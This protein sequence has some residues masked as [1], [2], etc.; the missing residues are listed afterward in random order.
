MKT[1]ISKIPGIK[2]IYSL[3]R[4]CNKESM[5]KLYFY[6]QYGR[7]FKCKFYN[8]SLIHEFNGK[9][10]R[11]DISDHLGTIFFFATSAN[12]KLMVELG[13]RGG[14][15]TRALLAA[16]S[17][18]DSIVLS[19][20]IDDCEDINISSKERWNFV[21]ADDIEFCKKE[22][23]NWCLNRSIEP[24]INVLFIDTSH[25]Y[26]HTKE[27]IK[28]WSKY[29]ADNGIM[30]FHDTNNGKGM[31]VRH[32]GSIDIG[33]D[34]HKRG[35]IKAIEEFLDCQYDENSFFS[36]ATDNYSLIHFPN[37]NGLTIIKKR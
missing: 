20:D 32:D 25:E 33:G 5:R 9:I 12:P 28:I 26:L 35:V 17:I 6:M 15:S 22:F 18:T 30:I 3:S 34:D 1:I 31:Y 4:K 27:E 24:L 10:S 19:I 14:H 21:Q 13:T 37:C 11:S 7:H 8:K 36:D 23:K 29:L 2:K 16:A